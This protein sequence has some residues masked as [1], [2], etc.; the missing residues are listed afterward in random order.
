MRTLLHVVILFFSLSLFFQSPQAFTSGINSV[1]SSLADYQTEDGGFR[2]TKDAEPSLEATAQALFLSS[3]FGLRDKINSGEVANFI[4]S[5]NLPDHGYSNQPGQPSDLESVR[6]AL[7]SFSHL[8]NTIPN[9]PG[10]SAF[11]QSLYDRETKLFANTLGGTGDFKST[12]LAFQSLSMLSQLLSAEV[13]D[14]SARIKQTLVSLVKKDAT[15]KY[16]SSITSDNYYAI[17]VA[18]Y[19]GVDFGDVEPWAKYFRDRQVKTG[20]SIG[21]FFADQEH[22]EVLFEDC[23]H[24]VSALYFLQKATKSNTTLADTIDTATLTHYANTLPRSLRAASSAYAAI[25]R[26]SSFQSTFKIVTHYDVMDSRFRLVG[27]RIIQG[28]QVKPVLSVRTNYGLAHAGLDVSVIIIHK[29]T[30]ERASR[31]LTWNSE[32]QTYVTDEFYNS[33]DKLGDLTFEYVIRWLVVDLGDDLTLEITDKKTIGYDLSVRATAVHAGKEIEPNGIIGLGTEFSFQVR[34]GTQ[35]QPL[36]KSGEFDVIFSVHDSSDVVIHETV[37]NARSNTNPISFTYTL[38]TSTIPGGDLTFNFAIGNANGVHTTDH[39][40]Y[41]LPLTMVATS[42]EFEGT[43]AGDAAPKYHIGDDVVVRM[44]PGSLPDLRTVQ[45]YVPKD[46]HGKNVERKFFM[47]VSSSETLAHL[48]SLPG[49]PDVSSDRPAY[50]FR[51]SVLSTFDAIGTNIVSFHYETA[52]G[53]V[54]NLQNYDSTLGELFEDGKHLNYTVETELHV[55]SLK[56]ELQTKLDYGND[57]KLTFQVVDKITKKAVFAG[58]GLSTVYLALRHKEDNQLPFTSNKQPA[59]QNLSSDGTP[60]QFSISWSVNPNAV[61]GKGYLELVAQGADGKEIPIY[62]EKTKTQWRVQVEIGGNITVEE[63]TYSSLIDEDDTIF[64]VEFEMSCQSKRLNEARL[65]ATVNRVTGDRPTDRV[66][67][68]SLPVTQGSE[69]GRYQ[70]SWIQP[71][72][73][74]KAGSYVVDFYREVDRR[75]TAETY[76]GDLESLLQ[77]LFTIQFNHVGSGSY[78]PVRMDMAVF[79]LFLFSFFWLVFRRMDIEGTRKSSKKKNK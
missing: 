60:S 43:K 75:R 70:L 76:Q 4:Q 52:S 27:D 34:L 12:A 77:P 30:P 66:K 11:I 13:V 47:D 25:A 24:A 35:K 38:E 8:G 63:H 16:F 5:L 45:H 9:P 65:G 53:K 50:I 10:L 33:A 17:V 46:F 55:G 2:A 6:H 37:F 61:K 67:I 72:D 23:A 28:T 73:D 18:Y 1:V 40:S 56:Q 79:I 19:V 71:T 64:I 14:Q 22:S 49:R 32:S 68:V 26:T 21:G 44:R 48:F 3:L 59:Q 7:L 54:L 31:K 15:T 51:R 39:V 42:I 69:G 78:V 20:P 74:V 36:L 58:A 62:D 41:I 57:V 29:G